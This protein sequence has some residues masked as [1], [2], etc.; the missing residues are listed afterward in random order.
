MAWAGEELLEEVLLGGLDWWPTG[1]GRRR[2]LR[3]KAPRAVAGHGWCLMAVEAPRM[4]KK[5]SVS[6]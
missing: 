1:L 2:L 4:E 5:R 6:A 3:P